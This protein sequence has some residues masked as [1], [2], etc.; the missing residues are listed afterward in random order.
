[1]TTSRTGWRRASL[2]LAAAAALAGCAAVGPD[3][4]ASAAPTV[5]DPAHP[6]SAAAWPAETASAPG[7]AGAAQ[8][9]VLERDIPGEWWQVFHNQALDGLI[10]SALAQSPTLAAAQAALRQARELYE[11]ESGS[12]LMPAVTGQ[13]GA[14]RSRQS[15]AASSVPGGVEYTLYNASVNVGYTIDAF[16]ATRRSL[17]ALQAAVDVQHWQIEAA[18]LS[19]TANLVTA[20]VQEASLRAQ[21]A[22]TQAVIEAQQR[23]L[24]LVQRQEALGGIGHQAVLAQQAQLAQTRAGLPALQKALAQTR[25][26]LAVLAG[27]QPDTADLPEFSL[28][29]LQLPAELPLSLPSALVRQRPDI[30][31]SEAL[32]HQASAQVGVAE[33]ARYPQITLSGSLGLQAFKPQNLFTTAGTAWSLGAGIAGPIFN[34]GALAARARAAVAAYDQAQAQ[35]R[36]TVLVAFQNVA[37]TLQ[38]LQSDA[39]A[40]RAQAAAEALARESL[41][42]AQSQYDAGAVPVLTLLDAQ[43]SVEQARIGLVQAQAA[44][45]A[46]SAALFQ[47]LGGGWWNRAELADAQR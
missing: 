1:M 6:Y 25:L 10:R 13:A 33:A 22:A 32:L 35:Y 15:Q 46:D 12:R 3:F 36:Q 21:L 17:E 28:D 14:Q 34:G 26:Q 4:K 31:A 39:D 41:A 37:S 27:R 9:L 38:A 30:R 11:A 5:A 24:A 19:L 47:A 20:A 2:A 43:R 42:L 8:R 18:Y 7:R 16:G 40:L 44:R 29:S 23:S 45:F